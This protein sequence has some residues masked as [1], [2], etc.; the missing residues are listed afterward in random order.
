MNIKEG[1]Q[2]EEGRQI[3]TATAARLSPGR[4][5]SS[6]PSDVIIQNKVS[7]MGAG[8]ESRETFVCGCREGAFGVDTAEKPLSAFCLFRKVNNFMSTHRQQL[9]KRKSYFET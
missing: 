7:A 2:K 1:K 9:L 5:P 4:W 3:D 6:F 8:V